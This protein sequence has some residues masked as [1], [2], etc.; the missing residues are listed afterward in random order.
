MS[1][2]ES[3][4]VNPQIIRAA[5]TAELDTEAARQHAAFTATAHGIVTYLTECVVP[6][7]FFDHPVFSSSALGG[8]VSIRDFTATDAKPF[9][10]GYF[11][12]VVSFVDERGTRYQFTN[13]AGT[14]T[15]PAIGST[16]GI[17]YDPS[18]PE[19][20]IVDGSLEEARREF[21]TISDLALRFTTMRL[22]GR[23]LARSLLRALA[24][25]LLAMAA[26]VVVL[27]VL[28]SLR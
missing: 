28:G 6:Y 7:A 23:S 21:A 3:T 1:G 9:P 26:L 5:V 11:R 22:P 16:V 20:A 15:P 10:T 14:R 8:P 12:P 4:P 13:P 27:A 24:L 19:H 25:T 2:L 17:H 18:S